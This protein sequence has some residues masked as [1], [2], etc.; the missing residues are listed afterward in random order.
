MSGGL[1]AAD[2]HGPPPPERAEPLFRAFT[3]HVVRPEHAEEVVTPPYETLSP[4]AW[5]GL[6]RDR[7]R[8][9][10]HVV[11]AEPGDPGSASREEGLLRGAQRL[12]EMLAEDVFDPAT[13]PRAVVHRVTTGSRHHT[14]LLVEI[15]VSIYMGSRLVPHEEVRDEKAERFTTHLRTVGAASTP[16]LV[17]HHPD[18]R[19]SALIGALTDRRGPT[20]D[21]TAPGGDR[22]QVWVASDPDAVQQVQRL[23]TQLERLYVA[24]GH[25]RIAAAARVAAGPDGG[26]RPILALL[27][28]PEELAV[29]AFH[30][31]VELDGR[32]A[33]EVLDELRS[34]ADVEEVGTPQDARPAADGRF[35]MFLGGGW[36]RVRVR[37]SDMVEGDPLR[38]M[39]A[40]VLQEEILR[41]VLGVEDPTTDERLDFV[42]DP[43]G[44]D[45]LERRCR[46][47]RA[48]A[49]VVRAA[50]VAD[51]L[52]VADEGDTMP[53]KSTWF[54]PKLPSGL[55]LVP[56]D[57]PQS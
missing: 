56:A 39:D 55:F 38:G 17:T 3:G 4:A 12:A 5:H 46:E 14:G 52:R 7:P 45:Q 1:S 31:C 28:P 23:A 57:A 20:I 30:R 13:G 49:F 32:S 36:Y 22:H 40:A 44:L 51:V 6:A 53:P 16:A 42:P 29:R 25:H 26:T 11:A 15:P 21:V 43:A 27:T 50:S 37:P 33:A 10:Q 54:Q 9:Y 34:R 18:P 48:V 2:D 19:T 8:S 47:T 41:P 35:G 24:D